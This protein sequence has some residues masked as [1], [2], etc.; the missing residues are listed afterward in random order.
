MLE[1]LLLLVGLFR[2]VLRSRTDLVAENLL[3]RQQLTVLSRPTRRRSRLR[4]GD[5]LFWVLT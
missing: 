1:Y 4:S 5:K 3:L 2:V